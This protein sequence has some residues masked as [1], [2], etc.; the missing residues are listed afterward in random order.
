MKL[1]TA[2]IIYKGNTVLITRRG[3]KEK[4]AGYWE[5]PGGKIEEGETP[6][7]C[8]QRELFEELGVRAK[9]DKIIAE[10]EYH[11]EHGSFRL[12]AMLTSIEED[13]F[14]LKVHDKVEWV[15]LQYLLQYKLAPAD[16]PIARVIMERNGEF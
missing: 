8:L 9:A 6:Q 11:Y 7:E 4:L 10:S 12:L 13:T 1:V 5:F 3:S 14:S 15:P 2:A 16:I